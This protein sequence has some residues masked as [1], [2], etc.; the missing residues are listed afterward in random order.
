MA[1]LAE[2]KAWCLGCARNPE[3]ALLVCSLLLLRLLLL[4]I[5]FSLRKD[6]IINRYQVPG[7]K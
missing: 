4:Q 1:R 3:S 2:V 5:F 7:I 6:I